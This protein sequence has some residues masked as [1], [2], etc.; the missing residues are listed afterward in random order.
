M[1]FP[2]RREDVVI[3][4]ARVASGIDAN[5]AD[6]PNPPY[7]TAP[8][9]ALVATSTLSMADR[10]AKDAAA[11][12]ALELEIENVAKTGDETKRLLGMARNDFP[13]D[14]AKLQ[15]LGWNV[16]ADPQSLPPGQV[17]S[18]HAVSQGAGT[19]HL[20]W[21]APEK[22]ES[23]GHVA[24]YVVQRETRNAVTHEGIEEFGDW[25]VNAH[26]S[27][28]LLV[29]QPRGVEIRY[30]VFASNVNGDGPPEDTERIVL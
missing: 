5:P 11:K 28:K 3:L 16:D 14:A 18:L 15:E 24:V 10:Q 17:R 2:R 9:H 20:D 4:A 25:Q 12:A 27:Q 7:D 30:R 21:K 13:N 29:G 1:E 26:K 23:T 8:L 22:S 6:F 19:V